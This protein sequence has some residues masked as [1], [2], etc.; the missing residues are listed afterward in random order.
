[1]LLDGR[2]TLAKPRAS[3]CSGQSLWKP[4]WSVPHSTKKTKNSK[5]MHAK[6][7]IVAKIFGRPGAQGTVVCPCVCARACVRGCVKCDVHETHSL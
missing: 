1:M 2:I 7:H 3:A 6:L 4:Q 5:H